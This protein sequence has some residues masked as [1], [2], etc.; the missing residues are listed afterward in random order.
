MSLRAGKFLVGNVCDNHY[1]PAF[2]ES[3]APR[4]LRETQWERIKEVGAQGRVCD[5][6]KDKHRF[7]LLAKRKRQSAKRHGYEQ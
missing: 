7:K 3:V 5:L 1:R 4:S 2:A 6:F